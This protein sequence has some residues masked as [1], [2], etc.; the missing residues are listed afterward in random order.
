MFSFSLYLLILAFS[1]SVFSQCTVTPGAATNFITRWNTQSYTYI[2][3]YSLLP[4]C[5][6]NIYV[7][8]VSTY[9]VGGTTI[10]GVT[11]S[12]YDITGLSTNT[13]YIVEIS[14]QLPHI[15]VYFNYTGQNGSMLREI[16]QWGTNQWKSFYQSFV[17]CNLLDVTATDI[18]DM[19]TI[20]AFNCESMFNGCSSLVGNSS[21]NSWNV[22]NVTNMSYMF[23]G[24]ANFNQPLSSWNVGNVTNMYAMFRGCSVFNQN[25]NTWNV[26]NVITMGEMFYGCANFNQPLNNWNVSN[27]TNMSYMFYGCAN[28]N[29]PLS[30]WNVSNATNLT[31]MFYGC[32][33]FN[34]DLGMWPLNTS[35]ALNLSFMLSYSGLSCVTYNNTLIGW[36]NYASLNGLAFKNLGAHN[37]VYSS[38]AS[39]AITTLNG[40]GW[41]IVGH[42][43]STLTPTFSYGA[44]NSTYIACQTNGY[45]VLPS[46]AN[47]FYPGTWFPNDSIDLSNPA[48]GGVYTFKPNLPC[49][50]DYVLNVQIINPNVYI[51]QNPP[52]AI[53]QNSPV[54]LLVNNV[55]GGSTYQWSDMTMSGQ[56][57]SAPT[58]TTATYTVTVTNPQGCSGTVTATHTVNVVPPGS[59]GVSI[60]PLP[61][62]TICAGNP[63]TLQVNGFSGT[64]NFIWSHGLSGSSPTT[65]PTSSGF[66]TVT[67]TNPTSCTG[68]ITTNVYITV[69]NPSSSTLNITASPSGVICF[70]SPVSLQV[71]GGSGSSTYSW[72]NG[73]LSGANPTFSPGATDTYTV[74]VTNPSGCSGTL[75]ASIPITVVTPTVSI[76]AS[77]SATVCS[78]SSITLNVSG[79]GGLSTYSW[80]DASLSGAS[81][82]FTPATSGIY[83]VTVTNPVG[84]SGTAAASMNVNVVTNPGVAI[85]VSPSNTIC[86]GSTATLN[87]VGGNSGSTYSWSDPLLSGANPNTIV[88]NTGLQTYTV[89][90]TNPT[91]CSGT[92]T[93]SVNITGVTP[94]VSI[95]ASPNATICAN[96]PITLNVNGGGAGSSYA[97]SDVALSGSNPTFI[98]SS[99][100]AYTVTVTNPSGCS[101]TASANIN[102]QVINALSAGVN[103]SSSPSSTICA[104]NSVSL[105]VNGGS[106][107]S[108][109]S[110][111]NGSLSGANPT[112]TPGA[113]DTYTVT[114]TNPSA[115]SGTL[116]AS[117]PI[118][119]VTPT[120]NI[121]ASP[122]ATVC[123]GSSL[124]LNVSG[125]GGSS[126]YSWS[127]ASLSGASPTFTPAISGTYTVTVTNPAGC[128]GTVSAQLSITVSSPPI[129][130]SVTVTDM[131][132]C[133]TND[134][135]INVNASGTGILQ[136]SI[137]GGNSY[138]NNGGVFNGLS[139]GNYIVS[140]IDQNGCE[141][142]G[143]QY[144]IQGTNIPAPPQV[145]PNY[146]ICVGSVLGNITATP[147]S[148]GTLTWYSDQGLTQVIGNGST[149]DVNN[150]L[151]P[152][153]N[154]FYVTESLNGCVS[155]YST[156]EVVVNPSLT[157]NIV[158]SDSI[159]CPNNNVTLTAELSLQQPQTQYLW[160]T[161]ETSS[162]VT[163]NQPGIYTVSVNQLNCTATN[164]IQIQVFNINSGVPVVYNDTDT[165]DY[166][167]TIQIPILANDLYQSGQPVITKEPSYGIVQLTN[168][169]ELVYI[170]NSNFYGVDS[171]QYALCSTLCQQVCDTGWVYV[172]VQRNNIVIPGGVSPNNDGLNDLWFIKGLEQYPQAQVSILNRWGDVVY[173]SAP[174]QNNWA[175]QANTGLKIGNNLLPRGTYYYVL[176]LGDGQIFKGFVELT[177]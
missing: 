96:N 20:A 134:G 149:I 31:Y 30:S 174:Y 114:V 165:T 108:T 78:G 125:G 43:Q 166:D 23:Y 77:P 167:Q 127:D 1:N 143:N 81:P 37:L 118:T 57:P 171:I 120:V 41:V 9:P 126:T 67:V 27:V 89:T 137:D 86:V 47:N 88:S 135:S 142:I 63:V 66:Y 112:F 6:Y 35:T 44:S 130:T 163:V 21:F 28:F 128:S 173:E 129:I 141:T 76:N 145:I 11:S 32:S 101:G 61:S 25:I 93:A 26:S 85:G 62:N 157:V 138:A 158:A 72:S 65:T 51:T 98:P 69:V 64:S 19:S 140:V 40:L 14:G 12:F 107:S 87:V 139:A 45:L 15:T 94:T 18:P 55:T 153:S 121:N 95:N 52:G 36:A 70:G 74:T 13:E 68:S 71:N 34:Q 92:A 122:S 54:S 7:C 82:T 175:G 83:T 50:N 33:N 59:S 115:C 162:S 159:I 117:I 80:S 53:C 119:V 104:G 5:N 131:S 151:Q 170:P 29:Q 156:V 46:V 2:R 161:G 111:S 169:G 133:S 49:V 109:Y 22:S 17:G 144:T 97:W 147:S 24:C 154:Y 38:N 160:S 79:G 136:Y 152:G 110:W 91:A 155:G 102:V 75:S 103:I 106:G 4:G 168:S 3:I 105:Q 58:L 16:K 164:Q 90:V 8:P 116:T 10:C 84:C 39:S 123:A 124:T 176:D 48:N 113:T 177:Y 73:S 100:N 150:Y 60:T 99:S 172:L 148:N 42:Y 56:N 132:G 146:T